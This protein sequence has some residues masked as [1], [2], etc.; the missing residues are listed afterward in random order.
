MSLSGVAGL[1]TGR[2]VHPVG[3]D[4]RMALSDHF[5]E[6]RARVLKAAV[7]IAI[8]FGV[9]LVF[10]DQLFDLIYRPYMHAQEALGEGRTEGVTQGVAGGFMFYL[11]LCGSQR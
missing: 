2:P 10:Y 8:G 7:I 6:L 1:F 11:K 9:A 3:A 4:G 5:R